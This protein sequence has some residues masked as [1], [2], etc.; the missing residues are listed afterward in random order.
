MRWVLVLLMPLLARGISH[1]TICVVTSERPVSY[2][3]RVLETF[4]AE[5]AQHMD[6]VGVMVVNMDNTS[7][8]AGVVHPAGARKMAVCDTPDVEGL[9][10]CKVRQG[11]LDVTESLLMCAKETSQWVVLAEDDCEACPG[12]LREMVE[13]LGGLDAGK[14]SMARFS[15]IATGVA[16]PVGKVEAYARHAQARIYEK[17]HDFF[18]PS[19]WDS[20]GVVHVHA[21]NLFHHIGSVSTIPYRNSE[22]YHAAYD[23]MRSDTCGEA[24][25]PSL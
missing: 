13:A 9:P 24:L 1:T 7:K 21:R 10:I 23:G 15:K 5:G 25:P 14:I 2:L 18:N 3:E 6:G 8:V 4:A 17:P 12:S 22:E 19:E 20:G 11:T 16:F